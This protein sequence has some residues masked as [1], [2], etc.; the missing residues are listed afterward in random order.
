MDGLDQILNR[1]LNNCHSKIKKNNGENISC[2]DGFGKMSNF[3][4]K[5]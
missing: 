5:K 1:S 4:R 3:F 2:I